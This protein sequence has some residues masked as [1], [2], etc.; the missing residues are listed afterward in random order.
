[1]IVTDTVT[2]IEVLALALLEA[3]IIT[4]RLEDPNELL[5]QMTRMHGATLPLPVRKHRRNI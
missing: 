4:D 1:M 2:I 5:V 3:D